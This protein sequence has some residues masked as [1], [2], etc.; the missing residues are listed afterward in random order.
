[1]KLRSR[2]RSRRARPPGSLL[3][4]QTIPIGDDYRSR[5]TQSRLDTVAH[6]LRVLLAT[7]AQIRR[8]RVEQAKA[9]LWKL[10]VS[11]DSRSVRYR[12][13]VEDVE[14]CGHPAGKLQ[15]EAFLNL[16]KLLP[17]LEAK[18]G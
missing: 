3:I 14:Q 9:D 17:A 15:Q 13:T 16:G 7:I 2:H 1:V 6:H 11:D 12:R 10:R 5:R 4:G 18:I 8:G